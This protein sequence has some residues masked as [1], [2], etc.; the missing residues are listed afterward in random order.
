M[1]L[2]IAE[3]TDEQRRILINIEQHYDVWM[4]NERQG[5]ALPYG[6]KWSKRNDTEY[7]Y[8]LIDRKGNGKSLG[9]KSI[10]TEALFEEYTRKKNDIEVRRQ[11]SQAKLAETCAQY[12]S[13]RL[14]LLPTEAAKI[15]RE[16]DKRRMLDGS[17]FVVGT[18]AMP[19][20]HIEAG[21][22]IIDTP[23]E[24]DD[25]DMT[26]TSR[27]KA[28]GPGVF[29][30]LKSVDSTYTVNTERTF[31]ARNAKAYEFEL[32]AAP[33]TISNMAQNDGPNPIPME[34]LEWLLL[35]RPVSHVVV[36]RDGSPARITAPDP[37]FFGLQKMWLSKKPE[38][39]PLKKPKDLKQGLGVLSAV[40]SAMPHYPMDEA[41]VK[42]LPDPLVAHFERWLETY[43]T[44]PPLQ[45]K[46]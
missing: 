31:Q 2:Y 18:N 14:P 36:G 1:T 30:L 13:L 22:K 32:L 10:E 42:A 12:R 15:L 24:T 45:V 17:L 16:A 3:F 20:Y 35:G 39:D 26:W 21:G 8:E 40:K 29:A 46:W 44:D 38:R 19:A 28:D 11:A 6:L 9:R 33:S 34:E 4:Q 7:L 43:D 37:R 41:F 25:F 5:S 27:L 23:D